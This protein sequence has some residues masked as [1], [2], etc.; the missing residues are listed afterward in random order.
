[1]SRALGLL[2]CASLLCSV[3]GAEI[4]TVHDTLDYTDNEW[5]TSPYFYLP[6]EIVDHPPYHRGSIEDW[7][8]THDLLG[9]APADATGIQN[10]TLAI[11][12]WDVD[13]EE[14]ENDIIY[15][16]GVRLGTL[17]GIGALWSTTSFDLPQQVLDEL[18]REGQ[19]RISMDIDSYVGGFRVTLDH[20]TL[21]VNYLVNEVPEPATIGLL[22]LGA[23]VMLRRRKQPMLSR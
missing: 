17:V 14:G 2:V 16:N 8:W 9:S 18:W 3:A 6:G 7:G 1:M 12:A 20:S 10:A 22:G 15:A 4:V 13:S 11:E 23:T 19:V 21:A 5:G